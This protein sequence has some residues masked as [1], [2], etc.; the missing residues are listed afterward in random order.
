MP[1]LDRQE[2][3]HAMDSDRQAGCYIFTLLCSK[4]I[5]SDS[6]PS[7]GMFLSPSKPISVSQGVSETAELTVSSVALPMVMRCG[8][9]TAW[10]GDES[11]E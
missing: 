9:Q 10:T 3:R 4:R 2:T 5:D 1:I 8:G 11:E 6:E 7:R